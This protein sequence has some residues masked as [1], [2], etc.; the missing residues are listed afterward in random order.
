VTTAR[1]LVATVLARDHELVKGAVA[2]AIPD[3]EPRRY[4]Y[5][6]LVS[7]QARSGK[8]F[9][10]SLCLAACR[11]FGGRSE[12]AIDAAV[13]LELLHSAFLVHDDIEDGATLRRGKPALH[14][15]HGIAL[16]LNAGDGLCALA[17]S[18]LAR[19][20]ARQPPEVGAA[21]LGELAHLFRRTVEGQAWELGWIADRAFD[22]TQSDYLRMVLGKTCWYSTIHPC[23]LGA[24]IGSR[25]SATLDALVPFGFYLGAAF[26]VRDDLDN[27]LPPNEDYGKDA[28]CDILEGKRTI[29]LLHLLD[30][31]SAKQRAAI[32]RLLSGQGPESRPR[33]IERVR[34]LMI[35]AG[36]LEYARDMADGFARMAI[37]ESDKAFAE[38]TS[39]ADVDYLCASVLYLCG[40]LELR[41]A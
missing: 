1:E 22:V 23:R 8:G 31:S 18:A 38:A 24:L 2:R 37:Q 27:L 35:E 9:R 16:A 5:D 3:C 6:L 28:G 13:A 11:A 4:L 10:A 25:G 15:S 34:Q 21:L 17:I 30:H 7:Y 12:D 33:R 14:Q 26:Q 41:K 29:P 19:C 32:Q 40:A 36:S 39:R 20:A